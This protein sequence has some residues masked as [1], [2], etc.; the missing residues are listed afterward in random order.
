MNILVILLLLLA[1]I[2][3]LLLI[4][5]IYTR[6]DYIINR[7]IVIDAPL[8]NVFD[9]LK[10]LKNQDEFNKWVMVDPEMKREFKG[11]DGTV[12]FIYGWNG[13]KK[14]GEGEQEIK[15]IVEGKKIETEIRFVRPMSSI[16]YSDLLTEPLS[17]NK[18][19]VKWRNSGKMIFPMNLMV[20]M[21]E[22]MLS[23]DMDISLIN[24]KNILEK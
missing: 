15:S 6:K 7:E 5:A 22:R 19:K 13:N 17:D 24:L 10:H 18:T 23:K 20:R 8:H 4:V 2:I 9:Y 3:A 12:G 21:I 14:V 11:T 1:G 16:A